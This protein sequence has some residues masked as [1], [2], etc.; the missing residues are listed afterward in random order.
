MVTDYPK[1]D[2]VRISFDED[3]PLFDLALRI[4]AFSTRTTLAVAGEKIPTA[5]GDYAHIR[6]AFRAGEEIVLTLDMRTKLHHAL[7]DPTD[8]NAF[9]HVALTRGPITLARDARLPGDIE[10]VVTF[11]PDAEGCVPCL[12][13]N[14]CATEHTVAVRVLTANGHEIPM[15]DYEHAGR[16]WDER[17]LLTVWLPTKNYW[18]VDLTAPVTIE[19]PDTWDRSG[20]VER[21][22]VSGDALIPSGEGADAFLLEACGENRYRIRTT[23]GRYLAVGD[24]GHVT[25]GKAADIFRL[26]PVATG[27]YRI[28]AEDGKVL[29]FRDAF[30]KSPDRRIYVA[31]LSFRAN[32]IFRLHNAK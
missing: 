19:T 17:S 4:P 15:I 18:A 26:L 9:Y 5:A 21:L 22:V 11:A 25:L 8:E 27:R 23:D 29:V 3:T 6:R 24:D 2:T 13:D 1:G 32:Q 10:E 16:T 30:D 31:A 14:A 7:P 20:I 28:G 12:E